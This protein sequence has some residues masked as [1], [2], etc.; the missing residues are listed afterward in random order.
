MILTLPFV[1]VLLSVPSVYSTLNSNVPLLTSLGH[2]RVW[3]SP[4]D[5]CVIRRIMDMTAAATETPGPSP[6]SDIPDGKHEGYLGGG[7]SAAIE[8]DPDVFT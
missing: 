6:V 5:Q 3:A 1:R 7:P 4:P 8:S 2:L